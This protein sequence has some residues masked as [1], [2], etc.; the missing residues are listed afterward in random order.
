MGTVNTQKHSVQDIQAG[1]RARDQDDKRLLILVVVVDT[2][3]IVAFI[4]RVT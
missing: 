1:G 3:R 4:M 2:F